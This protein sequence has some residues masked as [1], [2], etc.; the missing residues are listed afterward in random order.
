MGTQ[1]SRPHECEAKDKV[2]SCKNSGVLVVVHVYMP[3]L[4]LCLFFTASTA[5]SVCGLAFQRPGTKLIKLFGG[6]L[7][8]LLLRST[9][10][11]LGKCRGQEH[12]KQATAEELRDLANVHTSGS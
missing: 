5:S 1:L 12:G 4:L 2:F 11:L 8:L 7:Q 9:H 10:R 6:G 3:C